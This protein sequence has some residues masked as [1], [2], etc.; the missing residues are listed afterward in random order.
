MTRSRNSVL[1]IM[2]LSYTS[3]STTIFRAFRPCDRLDEKYHGSDRYM[4]D[5]YS[6]SC[7]SKRYI[8]ILMYASLMG[9]ARAGRCSFLPERRRA[10][11]ARRHHRWPRGAGSGVSRLQR[12]AWP[13]FAVCLWLQLWCS[14]QEHRTALI[15]ATVQFQVYMTL[16]LHRNACCL[17]HLWSIAWSHCRTRRP[18]SLWLRPAARGRS[19]LQ[20]QSCGTGEC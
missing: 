15:F 8:F 1:L 19:R 5:D 14:W 2:F 11:A 4:Y 12:S 3:T 7:N 6:T 13:R 18:K 16:V 9:V 20:E 17:A 10:R